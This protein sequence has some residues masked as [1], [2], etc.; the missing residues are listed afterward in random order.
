ML[1]VRSETEKQLFADRLRQKYCDLITLI[2][3]QCAFQGAH[4]NAA[5]DLLLHCCTFKTMLQNKAFDAL[6]QS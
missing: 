6:A 4:L 5:S 2:M 1:Q 3:K